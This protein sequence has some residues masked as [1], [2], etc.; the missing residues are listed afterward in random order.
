MVSAV[1]N[2]VGKRYLVESGTSED[3]NQTWERY[4]DGYIRTTIK[5]FWS[6]GAYTVQFPIEFQKPPV[7]V[8]IPNIYSKGG[9]LFKHL[10]RDITTTNFQFDSARTDMSFIAEGY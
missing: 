4:S 3:A 7:V 5:G 2:A 6:A 8:G 9:I 10:P 1:L